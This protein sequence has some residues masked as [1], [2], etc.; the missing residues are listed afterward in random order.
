MTNNIAPVNI[1]DVSLLSPNKYQ[2]V[3]NA[4][5]E[6]GFWAT[7]VKIPDITMGVTY[8]KTNTN[9]NW[10][11]PGDKL[12][13]E[14]LF[15]TFP[16]DENMIAW[17]KLKEWMK[18]ITENEDVTSRFSDMSIIILTNNSN[19]NLRFV[20]KDAFPCRISSPTMTADEGEDQP[21]FCTVQ[22]NF[23]TFDILPDIGIE[24][25]PTS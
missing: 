21:L 14:P 25:D 23:V 5:G 9:L 10:T 12:E 11:Q 6:V 20:F 8:L 2:V 13:F 19:P 17:R 3:I 15:V 4:F 1:Q 24:I 22:F 18:E 16:I 7:T